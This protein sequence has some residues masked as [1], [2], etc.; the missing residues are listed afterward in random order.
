[1][2]VD[3]G[4]WQQIASV[5]VTAGDSVIFGPHSDQG[6]SWRW[7]GPNN[8]SA[9]TR[10]VTISNI[11]ANQ[12]GNY[13]A[14]YTNS[15][16]CKSTQTFNVAVNCTPS[17]L[18]PYIQVNG[19]SWQQTA[20]VTAVAGDSVMFAPYADQGGAWSWSG[21]NNFSAATREVTISNIQADQAGNYVATYTNSGGCQS[22]QTFIVTVA[23]S[24]PTSKVNNGA[25]VIL[26]PN[27]ASDGRF[28]ILLQAVSENAVVRI[29]DD[30][31]RMLY[32]TKTGGANKI[33]VN[34][35]LSAGLYI[36]TIDWN[37]GSLAKKLVVP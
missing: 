35:G 11:L 36:V 25:A 23:D 8:F 18:T 32:E 5:T 22:T 4:A 14:T 17:T 2:Q 10:E 3:G 15:G 20:S 7:S 19:G 30:Q 24:I 26:Y 34:S 27:P 28:T 6:G 31:G 29:Y 1:M 37:D 9:F 16:G 13:V 21:P 12:A 33:E